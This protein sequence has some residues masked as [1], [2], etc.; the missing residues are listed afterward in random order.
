MQ[1][2]AVLEIAAIH[3]L[4][5]RVAIDDFGTGY[6]SLA[7]MRRLPINIIKIDRSFISPLGRDP[8][9]EPFLRAILDLVE[10][11]NLQ[12]I[13]EGVETADQRD[14]LVLLGCRCAQ[15]YLFAKPQ[16][17]ARF[18]FPTHQDVLKDTGS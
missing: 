7:Y 2:E 8:T 5:C 9:A 16:P 10:T 6:S 12:V 11:L 14:L 1:D 3:A 17:M 18:G 13:V 15:G 4:G